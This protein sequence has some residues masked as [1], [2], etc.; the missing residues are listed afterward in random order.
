MKTTTRQVGSVTV[1]DISGRIV[2]EQT[3]RLRRFV[4]DLLDTGHAQIVFNLSNVEWIDSAGL[5]CLVGSLTSSRKRKAD[6]KL[7]SPTEKVRDVLRM[8]KL[9]TVFQIFKNEH[10][11]VKSFGQSA[12]AT[13]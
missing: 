5:G 2:L 7:L 8:T 6:L 13:A 12:A 4:C 1:V 3:V 9:H 11:A 10:E